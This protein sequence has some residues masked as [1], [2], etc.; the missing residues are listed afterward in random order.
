MTPEQKAAA[1]RLRR[2]IANED[3][4]KVYETRAKPSWHKGDW[5][6]AEQLD[7]AQEKYNNDCELLARAYLAEHPADDDEPP[8]MVELEELFAD[9]LFPPVE[10]DGKRFAF[11]NAYVEMQTKRQLRQLQEA[12]HP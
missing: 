7:W 1:E 8:S 3:T 9:P 4:V 5:G 2:T 10:R 11:V 6:R 12:L